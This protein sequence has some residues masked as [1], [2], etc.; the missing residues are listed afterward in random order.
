MSRENIDENTKRRLYAESMGRCMNPDCQ[1][2]LFKEKG[3]IIEKAHIVPYFETA[4]N[5]Y[6]NLVILCPNCHTDFDKNHAFTPDQVKEWKLIRKCE[7]EKL[8]SKKFRSFDELKKEVVPMLSENMTIYDNYYLTDKKHL[9]DRFEATILSNNRKIKKLLETNLDLI[10]SHTEKSYSNLELVR[11]YIAHI[12][13]FEATRPDEEKCRQILFPA[14]INS[15]FGIA[16]VKGHFLPMTESLELLI[17]K[18]D[19]EGKFVTAV[20]GADNPYIQIKEEAGY[21]KVFL[22]DT[23]RLRQL[24]FDYNCFRSSAVRLDSLNFAIKY[25]HARKIGYQFVNDKKFREI[26]IAGT[27]MV[28][29]YK[30]CLS[31]ADLLAMTPEERT[32]IVNLH[33][34][35]GKSCISQ[36]AYELASKMNVILLT[37]DAFY[38]YINKIKNK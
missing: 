11:Q 8:F 27:K 16:P 19:R 26:Y 17:E 6:E 30:Y 38:E 4:D 22:D 14:D 33:N 7:L 32:I 21:C 23:P 10:Q 35:N 25:I 15:L 36:K 13:E 29:V 12:N 2:E 31:E 18:L 5:A 20:I 24:Y 3:D 37:M 9:W 1:I 28:F 34:W